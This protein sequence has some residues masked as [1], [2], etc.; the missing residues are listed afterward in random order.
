MNLFSRKRKFNPQLP[1]S[2]QDCTILFKECD[3]GHGRLVAANWIDPGCQQCEIER[4]RAIDAAL[5][6]YKGQVSKAEFEEFQREGFEEVAA[7]RPRSW[8]S[9]PPR[10]KS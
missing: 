9:H 7:T 3:K 10:E 5:A 6:D 2:M 4:L 1:E 8:P